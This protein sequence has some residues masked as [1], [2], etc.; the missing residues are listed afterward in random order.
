MVALGAFLLH[1]TAR[2]QGSAVS[3]EGT[4]FPKAN[5]LGVIAPARLQGL[6]SGKHR[7][8]RRSPWAGQRQDCVLLGCAR[9]PPGPEPFS[10]ISGIEGA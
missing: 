6:P 3:S 5:L 8:C 2:S 7:G 9:H 10:S 1:R 4:Q